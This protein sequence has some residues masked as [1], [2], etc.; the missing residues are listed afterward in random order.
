ME[1][2]MAR[3]DVQNGCIDVHV[4]MDVLRNPETLPLVLRNIVVA[5]TKY[6]PLDDRKTFLEFM[7]VVGKLDATFEFLHLD[8]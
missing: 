3:L 5:L 8:D 1:A 6:V 4:P 2:K 7:H